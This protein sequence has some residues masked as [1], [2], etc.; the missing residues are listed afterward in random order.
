MNETMKFGAFISPPDKKDYAAGAILPQDIID[1]YP[2]RINLAGLAKRIQ[3][4]GTTA[5]CVCCSGKYIVNFFNLREFGKDIPVSVDFIYSNRF[6]GQETSSLAPWEG[7]IPRDIFLNMK[8]HGV[9]EDRLAPLNTDP[10]TFNNFIAIT[11][12]MRENAKKYKLLSIARVYT[13]NEIK[14]ALLNGLPVSISHPIGDNYRNHV[15]GYMEAMTEE[16]AKSHRCSNHMMTIDGYHT[17]DGVEYFDT[18]DSYG[19]TSGD[20]G[21]RYIPVNSYFNEAWVLV[22]AASPI[23]PTPKPNPVKYYRVQVGAYGV[24]N[25]A[26]KTQEKLKALGFNTYL[27]NVNGLWKVQCG[28]FGVRENAVKLANAITLK[29]FSTYIVNY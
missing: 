14:S 5:K 4:Q 1:M 9:C 29:G 19:V 25:N 7:T 22:D 3:N 12:S 16:Y 8:D 15:N 24:K 21:T 20:N 17:K 28:A 13:V 23:E 10:D 11:E 2:E 27:V 6:P 26:Y 18:V